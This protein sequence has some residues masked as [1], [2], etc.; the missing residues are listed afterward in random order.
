MGVR[1]AV[2]S[3]EGRKVPGELELSFEQERIVLGRGAAA[4]VRVP[5]ATVSELH[6][7]VQLRGDAWVLRDLGSTNGTR[8]SGQRLAPSVEKRLREGDL[9]EIG[10]YTLSFHTGAF[11]SESA[12]SERT[13][14]LARRLLRVAQ[15]ESGGPKSRPRLCV[16]G[17]PRVGVTL[18]LAEA[19]SRAIVGTAESSDLALP[20]PELLPEHLEVS[21]DAEG[22]L[23]RCLD[24]RA[25]IVVQGASLSARRLRD[26]DEVIVGS[27]AL[28]FEEPLQAKL[29]A[30]RSEPDI[31]WHAPAPETLVEK[32][33]LLPEDPRALPPAPSAHER[34]EPSRSGFDADALVYLLAALILAASGLGLFY[35]LRAP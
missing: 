22:V 28:L 33:E 17:G 6:A 3:C 25:R 11:A 27:T 8:L 31:P 2:R 5:H 9:I 12:T 19:P 20:D 34:N 29:D 10:V 21:C 30:L 26:G 7:T 14:E 1:F 23:A 4:D 18:E 32:T 24:P 16:L 13:A 35:L 15:S